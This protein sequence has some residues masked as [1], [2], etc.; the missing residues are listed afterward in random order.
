MKEAIRDE[1]R[2]FTEIPRASVEIDAE[3]VQ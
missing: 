1:R 3:R 2:I